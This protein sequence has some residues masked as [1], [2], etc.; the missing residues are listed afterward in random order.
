M[1]RRAFICG[2]S[3]ANLTLGEADFLAAA[4][5]AG[6]ILFARNVES[7][8]QVRRLLAEARDAAGD[9]GRFLALVDQEGGRVQRLTK[10]HWPLYPAARAFGRLCEADRDRAKHAA[11]LCARA[12]AQDLHELG[13]NTA[14]APVLDVPVP[15]ADNVIGDRAYGEDAGTVT[16]LGAA[17]A[18]GLLAGG[19]L[20]VMKHIP[21]HGRAM[22]DSHLALPVVDAPIEV[23]E[24]AD[25]APFRALRHLPM[26][27]T[28]HVIFTAIDP[29]APVT[30]SQKA[31]ADVIRGYIGFDGLLM[32][33]DLSMRALSGSL[34]ERTRASLAAGCDLALHC[35][36]KMDEMAAVAT[37]SPH[38][39]GAALAR[40]EAALAQL[41]EPEPF[42][43][44]EAGEARLQ[45]LAA[46]A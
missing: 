36:G 24:A 12:M 23:L 18:E 35:N 13:F 3:G 20:P 16:E 4:R 6:L 32:S 38:L 17:V 26:A 11:R 34:E 28:A 37:A 33:D 40:F 39:Q 46:L 30:V 1:H 10:P 25:F 9:D 7:P 19:I 41:K 29:A 44:Q 27:M 45:A 14:C 2:L 15:G 5:P 8:D 21:G 43:R 31:I 22:A 42:D